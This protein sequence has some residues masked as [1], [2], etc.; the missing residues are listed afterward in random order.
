MNET[1]SS[2]VFP[3]PILTRSLYDS[4]DPDMKI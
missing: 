3:F 1:G 2:A 4:S